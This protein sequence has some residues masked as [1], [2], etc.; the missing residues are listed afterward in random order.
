MICIYAI[1]SIVDDKHYVGQASDKD[2]RWREHRKS[3]RGFYHHSIHLQRA[4]CKHGEGNFIFIVLEALD[5]V[6]KLNEREI[7]WG[8]L[9]KPEYNMAPLGG[10]LKGY[11]H[12]EE[13]KANMSNAHKGYKA[14]P[15][16]RAKMSAA[17]IGNQYNTGRKQSKEVI[18]HRA[19]FHRGKITSDETKI[20]M[21]KAQKGK[22]LTPEHKLKLSIAARN[23][24]KRTKGCL[25]NQ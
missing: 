21:S 9:L 20:K 22:S 7:Y 2:F 13:A 23:R 10:S 24:V 12:T 5:D 1:I 25:T 11:K 16:T 6:S 8:N 17:R 3:L 18:E 14:S 4:W 19:S 15:E